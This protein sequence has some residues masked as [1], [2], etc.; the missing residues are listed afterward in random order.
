MIDMHYPFKPTIIKLN[1][2]IESSFDI[3]RVI[4]MEYLNIKEEGMRKQ[5][6]ENSNSE[7]GQMLKDINLEGYLY[8]NRTE[9]LGKKKK[10]LLFADLI[11]FKPIK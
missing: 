1:D 4:C 10:T 6:V 5:L 2:S 9:T 8:T 7:L 11:Q 3:D